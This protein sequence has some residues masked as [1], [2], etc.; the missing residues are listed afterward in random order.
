MYTYDATHEK[1]NPIHP[2]S[3]HTIYLLF[4][5]AL[6]V[7]VVIV[8]SEP[9]SFDLCLARSSMLLTYQTSQCETTSVV[10][11]DCHSTLIYIQQ[12]GKNGLIKSRGG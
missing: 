2:Q 7:A 4:V 6:V 3:G 1:F 12:C 5:D 10:V 8:R 11:T 9:L